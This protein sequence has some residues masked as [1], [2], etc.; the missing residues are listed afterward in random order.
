MSLKVSRWNCEREEVLPNRLWGYM[1]EDG[2]ESYYPTPF[3][4]V[5]AR[6]L[7]EDRLGIAMVGRLPHDGDQTYDQLCAIAAALVDGGTL[8]RDYALAWLEQVLPF[9]DPEEL[10]DLVQ[11]G[12]DL[13]DA[14]RCP[15]CG[16]L[17]R[18]DMNTVVSDFDLVEQDGKIIV[19]WTGETDL[20]TQ[21][22]QYEHGLPVLCCRA[23]HLYQHK[24]FTS[25][26]EQTREI[27]V[28]LG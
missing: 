23:G 4:S 26:V 25:E 8:G 3:E 6:G 13:V 22:T 11:Q 12:P 28:P 14:L 24:L 27:V 21:E 5:Q 18:G 15:H 17:P 10:E 2:E 9:V 1:L 19:T 7:F 20:D 16:A